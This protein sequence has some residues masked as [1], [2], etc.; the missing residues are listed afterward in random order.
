[1]MDDEV[2]SLRRTENGV[3]PVCE[4]VPAFSLVGFSKF[5]RAMHSRVKFTQVFFFNCKDA[6]DILQSQEQE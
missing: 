1:M 5:R 2:E 4:A 3:E 6:Q